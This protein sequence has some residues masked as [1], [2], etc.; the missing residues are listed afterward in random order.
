VGW[1]DEKHGIMEA[2]GPKR[3]AKTEATTRENAVYFG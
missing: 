2:M 3:A 1:N